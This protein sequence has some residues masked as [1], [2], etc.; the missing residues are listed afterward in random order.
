[1]SV[2]QEF[3]K[4]NQ[5]SGALFITIVIS[6]ILVVLAGSLAYNLGQSN[7]FKAAPQGASLQLQPTDV[8]KKL[9]LDTANT[10]TLININNGYVRVVIHPDE[11]FIL[12]QGAT[13]EG[14][15]V[16][17]G[18]AGDFGVSSETVEDEFYGQ[19]LSNG[20]VDILYDKV[21]YAL[22]LGRVKQDAKTK[23]YSIEFNFQNSLMPYDRIVL[24]LESDT[25]RIDYDPRPGA[26]LFQAEIP[27]N[28]KPRK[29]L[30][31]ANE[32]SNVANTAKP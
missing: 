14:F 1:M 2:E 13:I 23:D 7:P 25:Q 16:D 29:A 6:L 31:E 9:Y 22:S 15:L 11:N 18:T 27:N 24:T 5:E 28:L 3:Q 8:A 26:I 20:D 17:A 12:P 4:S 30:I 21:P 32:E 10:E 19:T